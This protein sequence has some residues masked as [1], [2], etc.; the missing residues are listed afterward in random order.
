MPK[1]TTSTP[2]YRKHRASGQAIVTL[3]GRDFYLGPHG[4]KTS[5]HEYDRL[6]AEWLAN[7]RRLPVGHEDIALTTMAELMAAYRR[8]V[9]LYYRKNGRL[10]SEVAGV[11]RALAYVKKLYLRLP[12]VE[13]GPLKLKAV[14]QTMIDAGWC[15]KTVNQQIGRVVRMVKWGVAEELVPPQIHQALA[16]VTG[17]RKGRTAASVPRNQFC[18]STDV[19][20]C[21]ADH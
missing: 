7:G 18:F 2:K 12:V 15:R 20:G 11:D 5:H 6:I 1:L 16:S 13:F 17:L 8:F 9:R 4:T 19:F 10:T 3:D 14:R 21:S